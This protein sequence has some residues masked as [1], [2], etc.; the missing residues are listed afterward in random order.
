MCFQLHLNECLTLPLATRCN[1]LARLIDCGSIKDW[2]DFYPALVKSIFGF[3]G[4]YY[5]AFVFV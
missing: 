3:P 1:E 5:N 2:H 4:K